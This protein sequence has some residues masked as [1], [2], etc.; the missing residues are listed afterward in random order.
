M[1]DPRTVAAI[2]AVLRRVHGDD[3]ARR[4]LQDGMTLETLIYAMLRAPIRE[5]D[6]A[7]LMR[8]VPDVHSDK[9]L[10][11]CE[12]VADAGDDVIPIALFR[13]GIIQRNT[14]YIR[15]DKVASVVPDVPLM[16][17]RYSEEVVTDSPVSSRGP[18]QTK[19]LCEK[20]TRRIGLRVGKRLYS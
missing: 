12:R 15:A 7:R 2:V 19:V 1:R 4:L 3:A 9:H 11:F 20:R 6:S 5:R 14:V 13:D 16:E 18:R 10:S 8:T 17:T